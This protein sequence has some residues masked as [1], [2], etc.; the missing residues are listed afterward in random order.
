MVFTDCLVLPVI[1]SRVRQADFW[2]D[3]E[4]VTHFDIIEPC[5]QKLRGH[6]GQTKVKSTSG[7]LMNDCT[8]ALADQVQ[9]SDELLQ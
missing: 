5:I 9:Y 4:N 1:F 8:N 2:L 7:L 6:A 3:P